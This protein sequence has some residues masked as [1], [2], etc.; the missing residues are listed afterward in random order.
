MRLEA[1]VKSRLTW[2]DSPPAARSFR[3]PRLKTL[4]RTGCS[5]PSR[6]SRKADDV[7]RTYQPNSRK[8]ARTHGFRKRMSTRAG[9]AILKSRRA[10]GRHRL[11]V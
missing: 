10:K 5:M 4:R 1:T 3:G 8:R 6:A 7:K 2:E 9:R 11:T